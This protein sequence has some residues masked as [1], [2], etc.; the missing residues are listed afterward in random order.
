MHIGDLVWA[1]DEDTDITALQPVV[2]IIQNESGHTISLYTKTEVIETTA[3]HPFY[4][5]EGW[6]DASE[7][8]EG[9]KILT[10]EQEKVEIKK[11]EYNYEPRK[12]FNFEVAHFHTYFV[13]ILAWLVH[14]ATRCLSEIVTYGKNML[15]KFK[16]H[17]QQMREAV[18]KYGIDIPKGPGKIETQTAMKD[19][20]NKVVKEGEERVGEYMTL[21]DCV[22]HKL[23]ND[24]VVRKMDGE[25][26]TFLDK[27]LGDVAN[28]WD[29]IF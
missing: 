27:K 13:D 18:R 7:L 24:I 25:F 5:E 23:D 14:N 8:E 1:Y 11:V 10:K 3:M 20:I 22:W 21:G 9:D 17:G 12:I 19:F 4:T 16:K 2:D 29:K 28:Q 26:V 15:E 6:K